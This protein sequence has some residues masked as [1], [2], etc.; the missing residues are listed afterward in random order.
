MAEFGTSLFGSALFGGDPFASLELDID[1][2]VTTIA[3]RYLARKTIDGMS[4]KVTEFSL[5]Q[6]GA[7]PFDYKIAIPVNP[8]AQSLEIPIA[9][10][11]KAITEYER[12]NP[13]SGCAYC[14]VESGEANEVLSEIGIWAEILWSPYTAE[15]GTVFLAAIA[16][17][18]IVCKNPSM[19]YAFRVNVQF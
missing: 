7:D 5:G 15:I 4:F 3:R 8:G 14:L 13:S 1:A 6:G 11:P 17:F 16:H 10:P 2:E 9:L 18:P 19:N 12:P